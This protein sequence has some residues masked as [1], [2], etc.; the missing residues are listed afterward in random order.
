MN[1]MVDWLMDMVRSR[2]GY[3]VVAGLFALLTSCNTTK[4]LTEDEELLTKQ[5]VQLLDAKKIPNKGDLIYEL[6]TLTKQSPNEN[7][8]F[9]FPR[10]HFFLAN[11]K[12]KDT[13]GIDRFL[14]NTIGQPPTIYSDS[15]SSATATAM[16]S[17]LQYHGFFD[18]EVY[19]EA[20]A[21]RNKKIGLTYYAKPGRRTIIN[22]VNFSSSLSDLD[23]LL[24]EAA[25]GTLLE[26]G[27]PLDLN[28]Y[29]QE[30]ERI[31]RYL[32]N[33]GYAFLYNTAFDQLEV[34]TFQQTGLA[35][36]YLKILP[37]RNAE[38]HVRYRVGRIDVYADYQLGLPENGRAVPIDTIVDGVHFNYQR[39]RISVEPG[40]LLDNLFLRP[41]EYYSKADFDKSNRELGGLGIFRFVRINQLRDTT[42]ESVLNYVIQLTPNFKMELGASFDVSY[43]NRRATGA[44][45]LIGL[46]VSPSFRNRNLFGGAELLVTTLRA[47]IEV[48]PEVSPNDNRFFNTVDIGANSN[49]FLPR[50]RDYLGL[51]KLTHGKGKGLISDRFYT[52]MTDQATTR[53]SLGAEY[54]LIRDYYAYTQL[55][56]RYGYNM[57]ISS[58]TSYSIDHAAVDLLIPRTEPLWDTILLN[59]PFLQRSFG[60]QYFVSGLFRGLEYRREGRTGLRGER[61]NFLINLETSGAEIYAANQL[62]NAISNNNTVF[63]PREGATY[64][65]YISGRF[66]IRFFQQYDERNSLAS[67]FLFAIARPF[68]NSEAVPYVKQFAA[69][70]ANSMRAWDL[71]GLGPGGFVDSL[72]LLRRG[73][74]AN[75]LLYQT[76]D[77]QLEFNLEYRYKLF[78]Q[79][80]G[81]FFV[82][83]GNVWT[84]QREESGRCGSQFRFGKTSYTCDGVEFHHQPFYRQL[85]IGGGTGIR[86]DLSYFIFR[87]DAAIPLRYN[88]PSER[89]EGGSIPEKLYW[90]DFN[91]FRI[92]WQL[93]LGYPF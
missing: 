29:D 28:V 46:G 55:N 31:S 77:L 78:W 9:L 1:L 81:A 82:D 83:I 33:R 60:E 13:T 75:R 74:R 72:S 16:Q 54:L 89:P 92:N 65:Q 19:H 11:S 22:N 34:D 20:D 26:K 67:R 63:R 69:G 35:D 68:G 18:A 52:A 93:G 61:V 84:V 87:L 45:N 73:D 59:N 57:N 91:D 86:I 56:S 12:P 42:D 3:L 70:G 44:P 48:N 23:S 80:R 39:G 36:L 76:G 62:Y 17:Y 27:K 8:L 2:I 5:E 30:K 58:T 43:T 50:F 88:Y 79:L 24:Q 15:L 51:Y 90:N 49:I 37:P 21:Y 14:R 6:G 38:K 25:P 47:G 53:F 4:Y 66:D 40:T 32:R 41:G 10:E 7:F 85:A 64:A 71:R